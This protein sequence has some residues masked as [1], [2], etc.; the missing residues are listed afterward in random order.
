MANE[1]TRA[2]YEAPEITD[3]GSIEEITQGALKVNL[4]DFPVGARLISPSGGV[5]PLPG[6]VKLPLP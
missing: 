1:T 3:F 4:D 2:T 5:R 6:D